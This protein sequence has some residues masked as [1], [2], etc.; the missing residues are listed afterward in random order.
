MA[1]YNGEL[2][3]GGDFHTAGGIPAKH[4]AKWNGTNW[5][6]VGTGMDT[7]VRTLCI[8]N[9]ALYAGGDFVTAG[10]APANHIAKWNGTTWSAVGTGMDTTVNALCVYNG[11][12]YAGGLF[13]TA[14]G[15]PA[16]YIAKLDTTTGI[17]GNF[18]NDEVIIYPNP[19]INKLYIKRTKNN[20]M[21]VSLFD[22]IGNQVCAV[23][24][25]SK[26]TIAMD[27]SGLKE[28]IYFVNIKTAEGL[29]N[30]KIVIQK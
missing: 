25:S 5:T 23:I 2:Y 19:A 6:A 12:L 4:I 14:G 7:T 27:I 3:A 18:V 26:Q 13:S 17:R 16:N 22:I 8:Y 10:G 28:G 21:E 30:K 1:V 29:L 15:N 24:K 20:F 9:N 11:E